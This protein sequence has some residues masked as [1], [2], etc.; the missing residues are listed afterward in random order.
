MKQEKNNRQLP[1]SAV[2][3][4]DSTMNS[5]SHSNTTIP[6]FLAPK[7]ENMPQLLKN[8]HQWLLWMPAK[9]GDK[10]TKIPISIHAT[11]GNVNVPDTWASFDEVS[12]ACRSIRNMPE[13]TQRNVGIGFVFTKDDPF[14]GIDLDNCFNENGLLHPLAREIVERLSSYTELSVSGKGLHIINMGETAEGK[15][16]GPV[17]IYSQGRYFTMSGHIFEGRSEITDGSAALAEIQKYLSQKN[18]AK[19]SFPPT[20]YSREYQRNIDEGY[21]YAEDLSDER[22]LETL[23]RS[24]NGLAFKRLWNGD[25]SDYDYD[26]SRADLALLGILVWWCNG[27]EE[28]V[29]RLFR[30]SGLCRDKWVNRQDY[31]ERSFEKFQKKGGASI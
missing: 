24:R 2:Q 30:Q 31:R 12:E 13:S 19:D 3:R 20:Q 10:W 29:D 9:R 18:S 17:E 6:E 27:D 11:R 15:R 21:V 1:L 26:H 4:G 14:V 22:L 25:I 7:P 23:R 28:R 8:L 16:Y 5:E